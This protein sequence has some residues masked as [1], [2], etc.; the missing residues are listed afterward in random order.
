MGRVE[1]PSGDQPKARV[2]W[3]W[4]LY[5]IPRRRRGR[6]RVMSGT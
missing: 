1:A 5:F 6:N 4:I 3:A 2:L